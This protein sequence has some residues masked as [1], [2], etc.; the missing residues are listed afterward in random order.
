MYLAVVQNRIN[1]AP[2]GIDVT[3]IYIWAGIILAAIGAIWG[4]KKMIL[5]GYDS[6][7]DI[8]E[9]WQARY[10]REQDNIAYKEFRDSGGFEDDSDDEFIGSAGGTSWYYDKEGKV[11]S[12]DDEDINIGWDK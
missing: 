2:I 1:F 7:G 11:Y 3:D 4:I 8:P 5:L 9:H 6:S 12:E 10:D